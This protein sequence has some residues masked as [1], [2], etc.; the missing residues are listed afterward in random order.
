MVAAHPDDEILGCGGTI[1]R[2]GPDADFYVLVLTN[3]VSGRYRD[4]MAAVLQDDARRA[5]AVV[6]TREVFFEDL[7]NQGLDRI[8]LTTVIQVIERYLERLRPARL[9]THASVDLNADH[10]IVYE[11]SLTA[12]RPM[13]AQTVRQIYSYFVPSSS[14]WHR[15]DRPFCADTVVDIGATLDR[16]IAALQHYASECRRFPHPR[17]EAGLRTQAAF[18]GMSAGI[19]CG[20]PF[21]LVRR[22]GDL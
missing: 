17:S 5:N 2:Y 1:A 20:E 3:G 12:A 6:G 10:R 22:V 18:W 19:A 11:A 9:F 14:E 15:P 13:L 16:K 7:P 21:H 8:A 4:E